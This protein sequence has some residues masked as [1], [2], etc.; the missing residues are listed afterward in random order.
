MGCPQYTVEQVLR[1]RLATLPC[2]QR[3]GATEFT[4]AT[5][6]ED[7]VIASLRDGQTGETRTVRAAFLAGCDGA[8]SR[9]RQVMGARMEG[10]HAFS[11]NFNMILRIP[12]FVDAPPSPKAI[13][14]W[15][16]NTR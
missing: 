1:E 7:G 13:M 14:Y 9:V 5:Q 6:D 15:I 4:D 3:L 11:H 2:V 16:V 10:D 12:E 8:R